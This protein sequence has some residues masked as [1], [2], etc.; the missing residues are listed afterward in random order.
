MNLLFFEQVM[1]FD[2]GSIL[3]KSKKRDIRRIEG[4]GMVAYL[5]RRLNS[6]I[7]KSLEM[8][9]EGRWPHTAP[10]NEYLHICALQRHQLPVMN[11]MATGEQRRFGFPE[12]GFILVEEVKGVP[13]ERKLYECES[14]DLR[15]KLLRSY[16]QLIARLHQKGFYC[17]LRL[18]DI[19]V[20][21]DRESWVMIDRETRCPHSHFRSKFRARRSI[22]IAFRRTTRACPSFDEAQKRVVM[23]AYQET[24][25][26]PK[27]SA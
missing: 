18:K 13:L 17:P 22:D 21:E 14:S 8:F 3:E 24:A 10:F 15:N 20:T 6:P 1:L 7:G 19:I 5:K 23:A 27:Q 26:S 16:G 12:Y 2:Q 11:A 25:L 9:L 4:H